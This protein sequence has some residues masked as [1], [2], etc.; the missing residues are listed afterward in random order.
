MTI[1]RRYRRPA[2]LLLAA[3]CAGFALFGGGAAP[4]VS[5]SGDAAEGGRVSAKAARLYYRADGSMEWGGACALPGGGYFSVHHVTVNGEKS[6]PRLGPRDPVSV[7]DAASDWSFIGID[8][9]TL[10]PDDFPEIRVGMDLFIHGFV[11]RDRRGQIVPGAAYLDDPNKPFWW[12][13]L[14]DSHTDKFG[15]SVPAEGV[16]GG[17]SGSCVLDAQGRVVATVHANGFSQIA[18]TTNTWAMVIPIRDAIRQARG[19]ADF[20]A[21][22]AAS[23]FN[24]PRLPRINA[25]RW[26]VRDV[27]GGG[28][29]E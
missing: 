2:L 16:L 5:P 20:S 7:S 14:R 1:F 19:E 23:L 28:S 13:E 9:K 15:Q 11:A 3:G 10:N 26:A 25:G 17:F 8:P 27:G 29:H 18:G 21:P 22:P 4:P 6:A 24:D 12:V